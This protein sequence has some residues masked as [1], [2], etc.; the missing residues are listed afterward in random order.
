MTNII[1]QLYVGNE[2]AAP[3]ARDK[4]WPILTCCRSGPCSH[5]SMLGYTTQAAPPGDE[6]YF[7]QRGDWLAL[8]LIDS[9]DPHFIPETIINKAL[10]FIGEHHKAGKHVL[11]H[12]N[13]GMS[14][15]PSIMLMYLRSIGEMPYNFIHSERIFRT[16]YPKYQPAQ[17]IRQYARA[18]WHLLSPEEQTDAGC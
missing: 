16:L 12:C 1:D 10:A 17:G 6:Y 15:S 7:A 5:R 4:G 3:V 14:R 2:T 18:H 11:V 8:N 9:E 13:A